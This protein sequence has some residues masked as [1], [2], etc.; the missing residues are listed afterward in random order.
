M[1]NVLNEITK[2][3]EDNQLQQKLKKELSKLDKEMTRVV[4]T[5]FV[6]RA[7]D[8]KRILMSDRIFTFIDEYIGDR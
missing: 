5:K 3:R 4:L 2:V 1:D 8:E 6:Q 7:I